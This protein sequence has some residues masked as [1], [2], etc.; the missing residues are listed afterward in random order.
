MFS[1]EY[2][3]SSAPDSWV[4]GVSL[5]TASTCFNNSFLKNQGFYY[6]QRWTWQPS[7]SNIYWLQISFKIIV[8]IKGFTAS[9]YVPCIPYWNCPVHYMF[10]D[11]IFQMSV[12]DD[13][14]WIPILK[15]RAWDMVRLCNSII[16]FAF[17]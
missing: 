11:Y 12:E 15:G 5:M 3:K 1:G 13:L 7:S 14:N 10:K 6:P 8:S 16:T 4:Y 9:G 17:L 2:D